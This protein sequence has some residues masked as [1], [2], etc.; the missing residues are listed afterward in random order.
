VPPLTPVNFLG[1][2]LA[3]VTE[4]NAVTAYELFLFGGE[5]DQFFTFQSCTN[6]SAGTW[7]TNAVL[8]LFDPSGTM[9]LLRTRDE[10]NT[11]PQGFYRT[12]LVP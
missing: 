1:Y 6:L 11:P 7:T 12:G 3:L 2:D 9:Y 8:E 4:S 5:P 10:T